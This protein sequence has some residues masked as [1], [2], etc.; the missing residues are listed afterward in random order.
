MPFGSSA[1][2]GSSGENLTHI[3][4]VRLRIT[5]AGNL[6]MTLSSLDNVRS[7]TLKP[8]KINNTTNIQPTRLCNFIEQRTMLEGFTTEINE[9]F[10]INR[11]ILFVKEI[12]TSY[13]G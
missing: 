7:K 1:S 13:P 11:V 3:T 8:L 10:R 2:E 6:Q 4:A 9:I 12:Y 5:G